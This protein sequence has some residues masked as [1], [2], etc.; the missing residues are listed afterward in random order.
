MGRILLDGSEEFKIK[1]SNALALLEEKDPVNFWR[2]NRYI[3]KIKE[4]PIGGYSDLRECVFYESQDIF[5]GDT[6]IY[7]ACITHE[8]AHFVLQNKFR[9]DYYDVNKIPENWMK[10]EMFAYRSE[11]RCLKRID[12]ANPRINILTSFIEKPATLSDRILRD[13]GAYLKDSNYSAEKRNNILKAVEYKMF[14][15]IL[16]KYG[17]DTLGLE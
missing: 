17:L 5:F 1:T 11:A 9:I 10:H 12:P 7:S 15:H 14:L 2:A 16:E 4:S 6:S 8:T 3:K 13:Y